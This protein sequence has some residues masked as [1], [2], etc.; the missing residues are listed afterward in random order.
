[1]CAEG[2]IDSDTFQDCANNEVI[3]GCHF[4]TKGMHVVKEIY[5]N[6][7]DNSLHNTTVFR[8]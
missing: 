2:M 7:V 3:F 4:W 6:Q 8:S 1:M 5:I